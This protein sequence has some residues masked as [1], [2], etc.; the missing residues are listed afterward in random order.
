MGEAKSGKKLFFQSILIVLLLVGFARV[1]TTMKGLALN[2]EMLGWVLI[3][4]LSFIGL[5]GYAKR[6]GERVL[7]FVFLM[8]LVNLLLIWGL[9][10]SLY[11]VLLI[12]ALL[13]FVLSMPERESKLPL[14]PVLPVPEPV[15][16]VP[17]PSENKPKTKSEVKKS[18]AKFAPGKY[19]ASKSSNVYHEPKCDWAKKIKKDRRLWFSD[20][21]EAQKKGYRKHSCVK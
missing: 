8:C 14:E 9:F 12:L 2:L 6:W 11:L 4:V 20:K 17:K 16:E 21:K 5:V 10:G 13:G 1:I 19:V 18:E 7:F 15:R 3:L